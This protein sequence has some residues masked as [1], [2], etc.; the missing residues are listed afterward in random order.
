VSLWGRVTDWHDQLFVAKWRSGLQRAA[1]EQEETF[2]A[3]LLLSSFGI[4]DPAAYYT[5][6]VTPE[7]VESF[8][9]WHQSQGMEHFPTSGVCC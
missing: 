3:V 5:I 1:R 4:D 2:L 6:D 7:L 8:H 9:A